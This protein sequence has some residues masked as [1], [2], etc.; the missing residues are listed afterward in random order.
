[1]P[2]S[3]SQ[4]VRV[5]LSKLSW[6]YLDR[7]SRSDWARA[8]VVLSRI[9]A[10]YNGRRDLVVEALGIGGLPA[11]ADDTWTDASKLVVGALLAAS[12][13]N[14]DMTFPSAQSESA[15]NAIY[16]SIPGS[17]AALGPFYESRLRAGIPAHMGDWSGQIGV[18]PTDKLAAQID[19]LVRQ[20]VST[21]CA[22]TPK[23]A[24][25]PPGPS[26]QVMTSSG[27][28]VELEPVRIVADSGRTAF[29]TWGYYV[30]GATALGVVGVLAYS[31]YKG[32]L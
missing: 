2:L 17:V 29:P 21:N 20:H 18:T 19:A 14:G 16:A 5:A 4:C 9:S 13:R 24:G 8:S 11:R 25:S 27:A 7:V 6:A 3:A 26:T 12:L 28:V 1:M 15:Y 22:T 10:L 32:K 31:K 30:I 23:T